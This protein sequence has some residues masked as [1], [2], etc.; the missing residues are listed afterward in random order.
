MAQPLV[1][2]AILA[3][4]LVALAAAIGPRSSAAKTRFGPG[5]PDHP[6]L[7]AEAA[8]GAV[9]WNHGTT[10]YYGAI[11]PS[12]SPMPVVVTL[13]LEAKWDVFRLDRPPQG[14]A[15][16]SS[17]GALLA[18]IG[19]LRAERYRKIVLAGQS[20][21]A[22]IS[23]VAAGRSAD[24]YAVVGTA[25]AYYGVDR[26]RYLMNASALYN[27]LDEIKGARIMVSYF[28]DDPFDPGGRGPQ[29]AEILARH[30]VAHLVI[31]QP[32]GLS[33]HGAGGSGSFYRRFGACV[34]AMVGDGPVPQRNECESHWGEAPSG[35]VPL[36][37][38]LVITAPLEGPVARF[39]GKWWGTYVNGREAILVVTGGAGD[40]IEAIYAEGPPVGS[41]GKSGF[42]ART[43][44]L[45]GDTLAFDEPGKPTLRCRLNA[46]G[47]LDAEWVSPDGRSRLTSALR[48]LPQEPNGAR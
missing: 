40:R 20:A 15:L 8:S 25:P 11:D 31:D 6:L 1:R 29:T 9:I 44:Q 45:S 26:P 27:Y 23:L 35:D 2:G 28:R 30:G 10:A 3:A 36:P 12:Q 48:R 14:E 42:T 5:F 32:D 18:A 47:I 7:G 43:G 34:L 4:L 13:F 16:S 41:A 46:E 39:V 21:G 38:D 37:K 24:I 19:Q 17:V 33:G 22:W